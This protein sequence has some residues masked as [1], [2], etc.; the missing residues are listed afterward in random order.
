MKLTA[1][2]VKAIFVDCLPPALTATQVAAVKEGIPPEGY[3]IHESVMLKGCLS[4]AKI[5][6]HRG[7]IADMLNELPDQF[8]ASKGGGWT[9]L[10]ACEDKH[11]N[12]WGEQ[13]TVDTLL[14]LG[15]AAGLAK[16]QFPRAMWNSLPGGVPYFQVDTTP[17]GISA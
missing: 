8:H 2:N 9:F 11:G 1:E 15:I 12:Q 16:I 4:E 14:C 7:S 6:E 5:A 3:K 10:N 13:R 17:A